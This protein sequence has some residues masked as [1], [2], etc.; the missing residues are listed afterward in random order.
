MEKN[1]EGEKAIEMFQPVKSNNL[2]PANM[3]DL[4]RMSFI[5][6]QRGKD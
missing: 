1:V 3:G 6:G 5:C 4:V 2:L